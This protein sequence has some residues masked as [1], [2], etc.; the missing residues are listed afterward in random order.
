LDTEK[1]IAS[2]RANLVTT[3]TAASMLLN[4]TIANSIRDI[5][6]LARFMTNSGRKK[7]ERVGIE[8]FWILRFLYEHGPKR[9]KDIAEELGITSSPVTISV[10]RLAASKLVTRER[11]KIDERIVTVNLTDEGKRFFESWRADR[12]QALSSLFDV[13]DPEERQK[14][15]ALLQKVLLAHTRSKSEL[16]F[17]REIDSQPASHP[18]GKK[19]AR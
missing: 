1:R 13:L 8:Q 17:D 5:S 12:N 7:A 11:G 10:K 16:N 9:I 18:T 14:L 4:E 6:R 2:P 3:G 15:N 19:R